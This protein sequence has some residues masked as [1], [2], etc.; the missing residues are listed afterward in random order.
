LKTK[1]CKPPRT[2]HDWEHYS[3][4]TVTRRFADGSVELSRRGIYYCTACTAAKY[5]EAR[6]QVHVVVGH[7]PPN[8]RGNR[9]AR[10]P[11]ENR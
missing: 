5:G 3:N 9:P 1:P 4:K 2:R 7:E 11:Q 8:V 6:E 10:G